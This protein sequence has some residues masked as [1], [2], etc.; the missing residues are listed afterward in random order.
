MDYG[1]GEWEVGRGVCVR[2]LFSSLIQFNELDVFC[3]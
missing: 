1:E 3:S 2:G